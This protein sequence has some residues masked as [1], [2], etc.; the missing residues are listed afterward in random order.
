M[1]LKLGGVC[2]H[3]QNHFQL[4]VMA[5]GLFG[6]S[7]CIE[8]LLAAK[9]NANR[10]ARYTKSLGYYL[11][12]FVAGRESKP[13]LEFGFR[14]VEQWMAQYD[15]PYT[16]Q[17][18]LNRI[19]T[20]FSFA[21]RRGYILSNP[22]DRVERV[23]VTPRPPAILSPAVAGQLLRECPASCK[24]YLA[25]AMFAGIRPEEIQRMDWAQ[26]NLE[27][28][29]AMVEGKT[30]RRRLVSLPDAAVRILTAHPVRSGNVAPK[31]MTLRRWREK[32]REILGGTWPQDVLR[33]TAASYLIA[34]HKDAA[35][36]SLMLGNSPKILLAHYHE[37]VTD[38]ATAEFWNCDLPGGNQEKTNR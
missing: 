23:T 15:S 13:L 36:V 8:E 3:C 26:I 12:Q 24:P 5:G 16:R 31:K 20:L 17:T 32:A 19:S 14:E 6:V 30:R 9:S 10:T 29:T 7:K 28:K 22:C 2:P 34:L 38:E 18:W 27:T 35:R 1:E 4:P 33:H 37:P 11:R 21:V 25:L